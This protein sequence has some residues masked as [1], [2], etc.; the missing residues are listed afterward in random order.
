[1]GKTSPYFSIEKYKDKLT[2]QRC[3]L[4]KKY[5]WTAQLGA[6]LDYKLIFLD[7]NKGVLSQPP[8]G[9]RRHKHDIKRLKRQKI[10]RFR[11]VITAESA[12]THSF[13]VC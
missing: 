13:H 7:S 8:C 4:F 5:Q 12:T 1:L 2:Q 6:D 3:W 10:P 9:W 11:H